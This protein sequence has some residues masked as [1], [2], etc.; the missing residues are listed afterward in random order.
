[1]IY[2]KSDYLHSI[3][4]MH[5]KYLLFSNSCASISQ[6]VNMR[7]EAATDSITLEFGWIVSE[8]STVSATPALVGDERGGLVGG[9]LR[10]SC[11]AREER[12]VQI[13][14]ELEAQWSDKHR[15]CFGGAW[16]RKH[17]AEEGEDEGGED[18]GEEEEGMMRVAEKPAAAKLSIARLIASA[19]A[20]APPPPPPPLEKLISCAKSPTSFPIFSKIPPSS[21]SN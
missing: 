2:T 3:L 5:H 8:T 9:C 20:A 15:R 11:G 19:P 4:T 13:L 18:E 12:R 6:F 7:R 14:I 10:P 16:R 21:H 17:R 1:L